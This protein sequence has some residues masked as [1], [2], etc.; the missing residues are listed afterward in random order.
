MNDY[1]SIV[2]NQVEHRLKAFVESNDAFV[3]GHNLEHF[4]KVY[5]NA[6]EALKWEKDLTNDKRLQILIACLCHDLDDHK[7][8]DNKDN[9]NTRFILSFIE[10]SPFVEGVI[11]MINL[12]SCSDNGDSEPPQRWMAIPRD[13]DRLEAMGKE[14]IYRAEVYAKQVGN[15]GHNENTKRAFCVDDLNEIVTEERFKAYQI[16]KKSDTLIDHFYDK[17]LHISKP[18]KLRSQNAFILAEAQ[19]LTKISE[20]YVMNYWK[21][22][23]Q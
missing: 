1:H 19:R 12:V 10:D 22:Q 6:L 18:E 9:E 17:I 7:I 4:Y 5:A 21:N 11:D 15:K 14:G 3:K 23:S 2:L 16:K 8:F 13:C 20:D